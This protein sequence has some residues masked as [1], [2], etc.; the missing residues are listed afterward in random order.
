M[1]FS[2]E[3]IFN[4][5]ILEEERKIINENVLS[6]IKSAMDN[7]YDVWLKYKDDKGNITDRYIEINKKGTSIANNEIIRL[8]QKGGGTMNTMGRNNAKDSIYGWKTFRVDRIIPGSIRPTN[9]INYKAVGELPSYDGPPYNKDGDKLMRGA[10]T[11][12]NYKYNE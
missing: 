1:I 5:I 8:Y 2:I 7:S 10:I 11:K 6:D 9:K 12:T 3:K 4:N